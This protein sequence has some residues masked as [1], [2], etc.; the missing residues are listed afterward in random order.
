MA[1]R[2]GRPPS[3]ATPARKGKATAARPVA[4]PTLIGRVFARPGMIVAG[5]S[6]AAV[7]TGIVAN[8]LVLQRGHHPSPLFSPPAV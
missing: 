4:K 7:M 1:G 3:P 6:F 5:A 8:A 2:P